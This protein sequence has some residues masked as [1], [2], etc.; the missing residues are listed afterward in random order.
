MHKIV[1]GLLRISIFFVDQY[2]SNYIPLYSSFHQP[3]SASNSQKSLLLEYGL[4]TFNNNPVP[5]DQTDCIS[6][7]LSDGSTIDLRLNSGLSH[8][9]LPHQPQPSNIHSFDNILLSSS[10]S[11]I[12]RT[13]SLSTNNIGDNASNQICTSHSNIIFLDKNSPDQKTAYLLG[14]PPPIFPDDT[15]STNLPRLSSFNLT[16]SISRSHLIHINEEKK[17]IQ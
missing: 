11:Y 13:L 1:Q 17:S 12:F 16:T 5:S 4:I 9:S 10:S 15:L 14:P 8:M 3:T 7:A 6:T 2:I